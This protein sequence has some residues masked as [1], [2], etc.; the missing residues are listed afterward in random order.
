MY[1]FILSWRDI[2]LYLDIIFFDMTGRGIGLGRIL[3]LLVFE[4]VDLGDLEKNISREIGL[5]LTKINKLFSSSSTDILSI[6]I[7]AHSLPLAKFELNLVLTQIMAHKKAYWLANS[8][9]LF[10]PP[11]FSS[12]IFYKKLSSV[13]FKLNLSDRMDFF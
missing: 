7:L 5:K 10:H 1:W 9:N 6:N 3:N 4:V 13:D 11:H 2:Y 8:I 12:L